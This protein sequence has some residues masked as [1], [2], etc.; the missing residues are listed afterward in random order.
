MIYSDAQRLQHVQRSQRQGSSGWNTG[1]D[2]VGLGSTL[3]TPML[4]D[5][6]SLLQLG[7]QRRVNKNMDGSQ[8]SYVSRGKY[9]LLVEPWSHH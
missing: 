8:L 1:W 3:L 6:W 2:S 9:F 7:F 5:R 4:P